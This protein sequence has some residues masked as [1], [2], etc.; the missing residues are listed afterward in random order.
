MKALISGMSGFIGTALKNR[1]ESDGYDV[2]RLEP[3]LMT[4]ELYVDLSYLIAFIKYHNPD[5]IFH[6]SAYGNHYDQVSEN[7][8]IGV[9]IVSTFNLLEVSKNIPY[10]KFYNFS[11]SSVTLPIQTFYSASKMSAE[12]IVNVYKTQYNK[13]I[14]NIRP[15]SIYG[16]G[17]AEHR[18]IPQVIKHLLSGEEMIIDENAVHDWI[19]IDCFVNALLDGYTEIGTGIK[20]NNKEIV[21]LLENISGKKLNYKSG[22]LRNYDNNNWVCPVGV[23]HISLVDGL[24]KTFKHYVEQRFK[25]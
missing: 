5:Y 12:L 6:L 2:V 18:F 20:T 10:K 24:T 3:F 8:I 15:Y 4:N 9:N 25:G 7:E 16:I 19:Y 23:P 13:P 17:E 11:T 14:V 21:I 1:L 22:R